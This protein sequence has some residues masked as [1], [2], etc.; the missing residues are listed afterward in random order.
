MCSQ[1]GW[2]TEGPRWSGLCHSSIMSVASRRY[3][4]PSLSRSRTPHVRA[5]VA[6][7]VSLTR[8]PRHR[9]RCFL[10]FHV[11]EKVSSWS[12]DM[13]GYA[14]HCV[15]RY[16]ELANISVSHLTP[17][18]DDHHSK[19]DAVWAGGKLALVCTDRKNACVEPEVLDLT[20]CVMFVARG[21]KYSKSTTSGV[22][23]MFGNRTFVQISRMCKKQ[24]AVAHISRE[25]KIISVDAGL[26]MEGCQLLFYGNVLSKVLLQLTKREE[27]QR[28]LFHSLSKLISLIVCH[29]TSSFSTIVFN[30][31]NLK[32][33]RPSS[34]WSLL[35]EV[36]MWVMFQECSVLI[37]IGGSWESNWIP[38]FPF[39]TSRRT[40]TLSQRVHLQ[41]LSGKNW[42]DKSTFAHTRVTTLQSATLLGPF[43][44][45][46]PVSQKTRIKLEHRSWLGYF[47]CKSQKAVPFS[48]STSSDA[49][50]D[51]VTV[52]LREV[53][54]VGSRRLGRSS[55]CGHIQCVCVCWR[56]L[57]FRAAAPERQE[58]RS[59]QV[60]STL[61]RTSRTSNVASISTGG[62]DDAK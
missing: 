10:S 26:R 31:L 14:E 22:L 1:E 8:V 50:R 56:R 33:L 41:F 38:T 5:L 17:C 28:A 25:P 34:R 49:G 4:V 44:R 48:T 51:P 52:T 19:K 54:G 46:L 35:A 62:V 18:I 45:Y 21:L 42:W 43:S 11:V 57:N 2:L 29:P 58:P 15:E 13:R 23:C 39:V 61:G 60:V 7:A 47:A 36:Q 40:R 20:L 53:A 30:C 32:I 9:N 24:T 16:Y 6:P 3:F 37:S 27:T 55:S 12:Y 59:E